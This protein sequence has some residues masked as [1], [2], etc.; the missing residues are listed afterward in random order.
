MPIDEA[1]A[2]HLRPSAAALV[3]FRAVEVWR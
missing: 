2:H 3:S 1:Y